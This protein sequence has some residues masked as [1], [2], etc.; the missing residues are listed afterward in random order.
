MR[1]PEQT[2]PNGS[3]RAGATSGTLALHMVKVHQ[4]ATSAGVDQ[5]SNTEEPPMSTR[6]RVRLAWILLIGSV[7]GWPIT[8]LT[9][10]RDEP[11]VVLGLSWFA[12]SLTALD[13]LFTSDVRQQ[14]DDD[15]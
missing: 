2:S 10:A 12:I 5:T 13:V 9:I 6:A 11:P 7:L 4:C 14:Q 1:P 3:L 15:A 8:A